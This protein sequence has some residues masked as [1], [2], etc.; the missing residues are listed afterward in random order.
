MISGQKSWRRASHSEQHWN[1]RDASGVGRRG[2]DPPVLR[3]TLVAGLAALV[4]PSTASA[5]IGLVFAQ[6]GARPGEYVE[7]FQPPTLRWAPGKRTG[8]RVYLI[9]VGS[10]ARLP[11][12][13][14]PPAGGPPAWARRHFVG[15]LVADRRG[16][17]RVR[18][19]LPRLALGGWTTLV[20]TPWNVHFPSVGGND[21]AQFPDRAVLRVHA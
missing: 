18:F 16:I 7:V 15:E 6:A 2:Y 10:V 19:R 17:A 11:H 9:P 5:A 4:L 12:T 20:W 8:I 13:M 21:P 14:G 1:A 3:A